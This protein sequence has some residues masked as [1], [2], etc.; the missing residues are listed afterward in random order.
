MHALQAKCCVHMR[1]FNEAKGPALRTISEDSS[2]D[3][4]IRI[5]ERQ[6]LCGRADVATLDTAGCLLSASAPLSYPGTDSKCM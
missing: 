2:I 4:C 5:E 1:L 3:E 6:L